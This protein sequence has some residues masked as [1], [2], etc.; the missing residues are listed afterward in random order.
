MIAFGAQAAAPG[1]RYKPRHTVF[2]LVA[3]GGKV[4]CAAVKQASRC[5]FDLPGGGVGADEDEETALAREFAEETGY[6][7]TPQARL[8]EAGQYFT[9]S[10]GQSRVYS[11]GGFWTA[12]WAGA[13]VARAEENHRA[14][15]LEAPVAIASL[16][17]E[18]HAWFV[19]QWLRWSERS[20]QDYG[21]ASAERAF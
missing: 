14:V 19:A 18:S 13:H 6:V 12:A 10:N 8:A 5:Y 7:V 1:L 20:Q 17:H 2:G 11:Y 3:D 4:L 16:R 15:W 21:R 9:R